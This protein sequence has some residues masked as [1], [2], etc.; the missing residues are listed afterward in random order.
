LRNEVEVSC[1]EPGRDGH[2][3]LAAEA[4]NHRR[5]I[6][7]FDPDCTISGLEHALENISVDKARFVWNCLLL[8]NARA[9]QGVVE[10]APWHTY[11]QAYK[12][13]THSP[14]GHLVTESKWLPDKNDEFHRPGEMST[15]HL[16]PGFELNE[17]LTKKLGMRPAGLVSLSEQTNIS[18]E[19][20]DL[21]RKTPGLFEEFI[22]WKETRP[23]DE[24][25][26][27]GEFPSDKSSN[28]GRRE[29][30]KSEAHEDESV[31][32]S[33]QRI[34]TVRTTAD[35]EAAKTYLEGEYSD[36]SGSL[37]CQ[38]CHRNLDKS[39]FRK[40]DESPY[41]EAVEIFPNG[42]LAK[43]DRAAYVLLCPLCAAK[44]KELVKK[45]KE[46]DSQLEL[47]KQ[48][49]LDVNP[50][51]VEEKELRVELELN[52]TTGALRFVGKHWSDLRA[53]LRSES[54]SK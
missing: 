32:E 20:L 5:G 27:E 3:I 43:E 34:R 36:S 17:L 46:E 14:T 18:V 22:Q 40:R 15:D 9:I 4:R 25:E 52:G 7:G 50:A 45:Q 37:W 24:A 2:V 30:N 38:L 41:F 23:R 11:K 51:D 12:Q 13:E 54:K 47:I 49:L 19:H 42:Y 1:R 48:R 10:S 29:A 16:L 33:Q 8:P 26:E 44:Y 6:D 35:P 53:I 21:L 39:S 31:K 28:Y